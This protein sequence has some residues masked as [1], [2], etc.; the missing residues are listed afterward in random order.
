VTSL[1][2]LLFAG[3][4]FLVEPAQPPVLAMNAPPPPQI[5]E[6]DF[7]LSAQSAYVVDLESGMAVYAKNQHEERAVAS[8]TKLMTA[9]LVF[10]DL[11]FTERVIISKKAAE[12]IGSQMYLLMGEEITVRNLAKG[13]LIRSGNDAAV[14]LAEKHSGSVDAF[15]DAM[16]QRAHF[17]GLRHTQFKNPHGLDA[18]GAY[19]TAFEITLLAKRALQYSE[20]RTIVNTRQTTVTDV[21][22]GIA[23]E[24][25][26]T[27]TL[28]SSPFPISGIKTGTTDNAGQSF[29]GLATIDSREYIITILGSEDRFLD[30]KALIWALENRT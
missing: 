23:H 3:Q 26:T 6:A 8:L 11:D 15:V 1:L 21:S 28:L 10:E 24:L 16:N 17:L 29:I 22:G 14:A 12:V 5:I 30:T 25:N 13:L 7:E 2:T 27:N 19:S 20:L 9:L 18:D 4:F